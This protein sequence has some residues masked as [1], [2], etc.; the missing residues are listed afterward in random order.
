MVEFKPHTEACG[1]QYLQLQIYSRPANPRQPLATLRW[2]RRHEQAVSFTNVF[3][4]KELCPEEA[5]RL[6]EQHARASHVSVVYV[7]ESAPLAAPPG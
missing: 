7:E 3:T 5:R 2:A 4:A 1:P 6:A